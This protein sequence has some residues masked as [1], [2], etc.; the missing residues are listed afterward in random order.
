M[1][2]G[3][4]NKIQQQRQA[5]H[6]TQ[7]ALASKLHVTRQTV[8]RWENESTYP[9]LD[10][11]IALSDELH[12]SLDDLLRADDEPAIVTNLS[13]EVRRTRKYRR[14][15]WLIGIVI[16]LG[17]GYLGLLSWGRY[18]QIVL[19][20]RTNPF[21]PTVRGF[22]VLPEQTPTKRVRLTVTE[23]GKTTKQ[24]RNEPQPVKAYVINDVFQ[25][26]EWLDFEVGEIPEK[27]MNYVYVQHKGSYVSQVRLIH[28]KDAP[29][30][31]QTQL[32]SYI[33]YNAKIGDNRR[34]FLPFN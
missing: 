2:L 26:G 23:N 21:L 25:T 28:K 32:W 18:N 19:I 13:R 16:V 10:L 1:T 5:L 12:L 7:Q 3:F 8:S 30:L 11:L 24:W 15:L 4:G 6:L 14:W 22:A 34:T 17:I 9:N 29:K 27:G 31:I 20:D 33:P